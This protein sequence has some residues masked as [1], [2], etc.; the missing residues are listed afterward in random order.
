MFKRIAR[1]EK[2]YK[3]LIIIIDL[4]LINL[5]IVL[6]FLI[7]FNFSLPARNF[8]SYIAAAPYITIAALIYMDV[9]G[10][11]NFYRKTIYEALSSILFVVIFLSIT[12]MA[13]TYF[14]H[15]FSFPRTVLVTAPIIQFMLLGIWKTLLLKVRSL[16]VGNRGIMIIGNAEDL[17]SIAEKVKRTAENQGRYIRHIITKSDIA[18]AQKRLVDVDE[19]FICDDVPAEKKIR[20]YIRMPGKQKDHLHCTAII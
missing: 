6:A 17:S 14:K 4:G 15:E 19:V 10:M 12:T 8:N 1:A 9:Y 3:T 13:I 11:L 2:L 20:D 5:A 7:K 16:V 18:L